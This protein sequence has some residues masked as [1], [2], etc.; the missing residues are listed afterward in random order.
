LRTEL[1][2]TLLAGF[3]GGLS[4]TLWGGLI[5]AP[6]LARTRGHLPR[7]LRTETASRLLIGAALYGVCGAAAGLLFWLGWALVALVDITWPM[8]GLLYGA[9]LWAAAALPALSMPALRL[10]TLLRV[11]LVQLLEAFVTCASIG[12]LCAFVW[13]RTA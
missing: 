12:V 1:L 3:A 9:L 11:A 6:L 10:D 5:S 8:V 7:E 13:H 2:M 4:G